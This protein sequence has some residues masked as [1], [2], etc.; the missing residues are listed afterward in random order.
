M[1]FYTG[2]VL[3]LQ[4][5]REEEQ[6]K[7]ENEIRA[8]NSERLQRADERAEAMFN[9]D[10]RL[11][12]H[13]LASSF[14]EKLGIFSG[15]KA[16]PEDRQN[17][18]LLS[19]RLSGV[20]GADTFLAP[21][22]TNPSLA[23]TAMKSILDAE[24]KGEGRVQIG[25][26]AIMNLLNVVGLE[27]LQDTVS[28][29]MSTENIMTAIEGTDEEFN[30]LVQ[31][32]A[33]SRSTRTPAVDIDPSMYERPNADFLEK[34]EKIYLAA[35]KQAATLHLKSGGL[36]EDL[37]IFSQ[38]NQAIKDAKPDYLPPILIQMYGEAAF[39]TMSNMSDPM[40][41]NLEN[42]IFLQPYLQMWQTQ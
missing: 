20:E 4:D 32:A 36:G 24:E 10:Q 39:N 9:L 23:T 13:E 18:S 3:G 22:V 42:N 27:N 1:G 35:I 5:V 40:Y 8:A 25:G 29:Y 6:R 7:I 41:A 33:E 17:L 21:F 31:A 16:S 38:V 37:V 30:A 2:L 11:K 15:S 14:A 28:N 19:S 34:Q 26:E 12:K